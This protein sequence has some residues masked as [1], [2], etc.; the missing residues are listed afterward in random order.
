M[1]EIKIT[2]NSIPELADKLLAMG[3]AL[4]VQSVNDADNAAREAMQAERGRARAEIAAAAA[5][6]PTL[7]EIIQAEAEEIATAKRTRKKAEQAPVTVV[8]DAVEEQVD[9]ATGEVT[10]AAVPH[11]DE[12]MAATLKAV[13]CVG[14]DKVVAI[15]SQFGAA[16]ARDVPDAQRAEYIKL[17]GDA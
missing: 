4:R 16:K 3:S 1:I 13:E 7:P 11:I 12:A 10:E 6:A 2:G 8:E 15:L 14:R 17:L 5:E 9:N